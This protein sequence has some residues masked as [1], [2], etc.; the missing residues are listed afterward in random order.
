MEKEEVTKEVKKEKKEEKNKKSTGK[1]L[2]KAIGI[3][4]LLVIIIF[5]ILVARKVVIINNLQNKIEEYSKMDN[6]YVKEYD[7]DGESLVIGEYYIKGNKNKSELNSMGIDSDSKLIEV[8]N[9]EEFNIY[10]ESNGEKTALLDAGEEITGRIGISN[11][12]EINNFQDILKTAI[13]SEISTENC[14]GKECYRIQ[15]GYGFNNSNNESK[16]TIYIDKETGLPTRYLNGTR[17][18]GEEKT[19]TIQDYYY[20]FNTVT[21]EVVQ[22]PDI[23]EYKISE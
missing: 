23:S 1:S 20:E 13:L 16:V 18:R 12:L 9:G 6:Y 22:E 17:I 2:L 15:T 21:D 5:I 3:I 11:F 19:S 8:Y 14:N 10:I 4:I 7:Y